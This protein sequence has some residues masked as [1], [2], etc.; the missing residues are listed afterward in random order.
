MGPCGLGRTLLASRRI[1][2]AVSV[3]VDCC[4]VSCIMPSNICI[5]SGASDIE[6]KLMVC[7]YS[8]VGVA[9]SFKYVVEQQPIGRELFRQFCDT[10]PQLKKAADFLDAVVSLVTA[11][12]HHICY[13]KLISQTL[14]SK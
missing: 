14:V 1:S 6:C 9:L 13:Q 4:H 10:R 11:A 12:A 8:F 3:N 2:L 5:L 7:C